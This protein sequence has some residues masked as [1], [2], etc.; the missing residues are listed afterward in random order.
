LQQSIDTNNATQLSAERVQFGNKLIFERT[1]LAY[2][3]KLKAFETFCTLIGD[4]DSL[5]ILQTP[6]HE[7]PPAMKASSIGIFY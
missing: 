2:K 3:S 1:I 6:C 4:Y 5:I 7:Y